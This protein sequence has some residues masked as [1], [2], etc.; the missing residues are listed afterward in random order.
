MSRGTCQEIE[1]INVVFIPKRMEAKKIQQCQHIPLC[2]FVYKVLS[3]A[4]G[5]YEDDDEKFYTP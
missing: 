2:S 5:T 4:N 3:I 1:G